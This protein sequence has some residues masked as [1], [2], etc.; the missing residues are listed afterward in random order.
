MGRSASEQAKKTEEVRR[1]KIEVRHAL[2]E[3]GKEA[4]ASVCKM[5]T[6]PKNFPVQNRPRGEESEEEEVGERPRA[7]DRAKHKS[8]S[9]E[10]SSVKSNTLSFL[11]DGGS[12][13]QTAV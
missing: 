8:F 12:D 5:A 7:R 10:T 9:K 2:D 11:R 4:V 1:P 6:W 3:A 13:G